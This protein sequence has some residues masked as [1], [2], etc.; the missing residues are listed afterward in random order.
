MA[1][2][3]TSMMLIYDQIIM[4]QMQDESNDL[5]YDSCRLLMLTNSPE[6]NSSDPEG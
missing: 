2:H 1:A 5:K 6:K 4:I 3:G